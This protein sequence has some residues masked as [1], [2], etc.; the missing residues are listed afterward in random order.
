MWP[1]AGQTPRVQEVEGHHLV[2]REAEGRS[3][4]AAV[5][6][7]IETRDRWDGFAKRL[8]AWATRVA[9]G[10]HLIDVHFPMR[11]TIVLG[12]RKAEED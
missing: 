12:E 8:L 5:V 4:W 3:S 6:G 11:K 9:Q 2:R 1:C 10:M 7:K